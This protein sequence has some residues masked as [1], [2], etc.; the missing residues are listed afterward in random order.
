MDIDEMPAH[1]PVLSIVTLRRF[2]WEMSWSIIFSA[3]TRHF[4][5]PVARY[6]STSAHIV[7]FCPQM[8]KHQCFS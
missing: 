8:L 4:L 6:S 7:Y 1:E 3:A 5:S 2:I